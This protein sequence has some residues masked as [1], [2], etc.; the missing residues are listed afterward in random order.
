MAVVLLSCLTCGAVFKSGL[1][2]TK[3]KAIF[4]GLEERKADVGIFK[5]TKTSFS[6]EKEP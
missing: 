6:I 4:D 1:V 2:V 5:E 3:G